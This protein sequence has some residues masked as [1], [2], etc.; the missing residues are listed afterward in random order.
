M[1]GKASYLVA[2]LFWAYDEPTHLWTGF[3]I[4]KMNDDGPHLLDQ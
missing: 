4:H 2:W 1:C 3:I